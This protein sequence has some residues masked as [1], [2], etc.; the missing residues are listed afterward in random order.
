MTTV[1]V[2]LPE[3]RALRLRLLNYKQHPHVYEHFL[4]D[5]IKIVERMMSA[6][7]LPEP[8]VTVLQGKAAENAWDEATRPGE[9]K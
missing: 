8:E 5:S 9:L 2:K 1:E 4:D 6:V 3:L 7:P